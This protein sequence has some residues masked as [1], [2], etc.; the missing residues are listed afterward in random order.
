MMTNP[1]IKHTLGKCPIQLFL[2]RLNLELVLPS[3]SEKRLVL[4][5]AQCRWTEAE[6]Q[7][8][9]AEGEWELPGCGRRERPIPGWHLTS[10]CSPS[11]ESGPL[12]FPF[13]GLWEN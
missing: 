1:L 8:L 2:F 5:L 9:G 13:C 11:E 7:A 10:I 4:Q 3:K 12:Y 6:P